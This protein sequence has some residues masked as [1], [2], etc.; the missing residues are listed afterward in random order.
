[1]SRSA[2]FRGRM[3]F[4]I[5]GP[6]EA[7]DGDRRLDLPSGRGRAMLALLLL[8]AGEPVGADRI[9][10]ELWGD[11]APRTAGTVVQGLVS[12]LRR[13]LEP[14]RPKGSF[15]ELIETVGQGYRLTVEQEAIDANRFKRLLDEARRGPLEERSSKLSLALGLWRGPALADFTY[16]PFAQAA[17]VALDELRIGAIEDRFDADLAGGQG[18]SLVGELREQIAIHPYRERLR[19]LLMLALYRSGRQ[20]EALEAYRQARSQIGEELGLEPGP[21]LRQLETAIFRQDPALDLPSSSS[22]S[23]PAMTGASW[24]PRERRIVTVVAMDVAV[25]SGRLIDPEAAG[26]FGE[27]GARVAAETFSRHGGR[28]ERVVGDL[29][30]AFFGFP[31]AHEDDVVRAVR[32]ALEARTAI[33]A[34]AEMAPYGDALLARAGIE[35]G[36]IVVAGPATSLR[37][38]VMGNV[39]TSAGRLEQAADAGEVLIG[40]VAARLVRGAVIVE[41]VDRRGEG[42]QSAWRVLDIATGMGR[43]PG[44]RSAPMLGRQNELSKLRSSFRRAVRSAAVAR[45]NVVG[46]AGIGKSRLAREF[47]ASI[48][49]D[50]YAITLQCPAKDE[51]PFFPLRQAVV[52]AAGLHGWRALHDLLGEGRRGELMPEI[53][54]AIGLP[55]DPSNTA[56]LAMSM[57]RLLD[58]IAL[59]RPVVV[60]LEDLHWAEPAWLD[61]VDLLATA[62]RGAI[63]FVCVGRPEFL[64]NRPE[65]DR[66]ETLEPGPLSRSD[67]EGLVVEL[68]A[69]VTP[70]A[71]HQIVEIA[72]GNPLY[73]EQLLAALDDNGSDALPHT[74]RG[75]LTARLDRLGPGERDILRC[76][77]LTGMETDQDAVCALLPD[78]ARPF[79]VRHI[80]ALKRKRLLERAGDSTFRFCH[81]LVRLTAYQSM[82]RDDRARLHER[83]AQWLED[84]STNLTPEQD[85]IIR[86][87]RDQARAHRQVVAAGG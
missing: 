1:M 35:T 14:T 11:D 15:S 76:A 45:I 44:S 34:L 60:V 87:H 18:S 54:D 7:R 82:T 12:R 67:V 28:V 46:E 39:L 57:Q 43:L 29:L 27:R 10:D 73:A 22:G 58:A 30:L 84:R 62:S 21:A 49:G 48:E 19:G 68:A 74:L 6:T 3:E 2:R 31:A 47:L 71:L 25:P 4:R 17:I 86:Y 40:P 78:D 51:G 55:A 69:S 83:F 32:A 26:R 36:E 13:A 5:L 38:M 33:R 72:G 64:A 23:E 52:E 16:E 42:D 81:A 24:L 75:L 41:R 85:Q 9:V 37:D 53:A 56:G 66:H 79:V 61:V 8:H 63:L 77:S 59:Q 65:W 70:D 80:D 20:A 50:A